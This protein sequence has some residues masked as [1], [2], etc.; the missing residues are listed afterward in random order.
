MQDQE[1]EFFTDVPTNPIPPKD[2]WP[3]MTLPQLYAAKAQLE[4]KLWAFRSNPAYATP[5]RAG[6]AEIEAVIEQKRT[7]GP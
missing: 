6:I 5:L 7:G 1:G 3:E 4:E 2:T